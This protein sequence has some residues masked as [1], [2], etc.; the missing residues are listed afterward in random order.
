[1]VNDS[2]DHC[3]GHTCELF[4][5][6]R[7]F[8]MEKFYGYSYG[9]FILIII[10]MAFLIWQ[11][12]KRYESYENQLWLSHILYHLVYHWLHLWNSLVKI[13]SDFMA[14]GKTEHSYPVPI[15]FFSIWFNLKDNFNSVI[16]NSFWIWFYLII[17]DPVCY[18]WLATESEDSVAKSLKSIFYCF[19]KKTSF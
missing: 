6:Q 16:S 15:A 9:C 2:Y 17:S 3:F 18:F 14:I 5:T 11:L 10:V 13:W 7:M 4:E 12:I 1:M 8:S 19:S